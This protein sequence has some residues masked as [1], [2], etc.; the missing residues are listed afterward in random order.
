MSAPSRLQL[1]WR[2]CQ[3]CSSLHAALVCHLCKAPLSF[4]LLDD[5]T[6]SSSPFEE[7]SPGDEPG[8][9]FS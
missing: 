4:E 1:P 5:F 3:S 8:V 7:T 2:R 9:S 6:V